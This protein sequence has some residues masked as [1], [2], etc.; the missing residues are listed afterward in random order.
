MGMYTTSLVTK[1]LCRRNIQQKS[2]VFEINA[3]IIFDMLMTY[4]G[5]YSATDFRKI[6]ILVN[7]IVKNTTS[8]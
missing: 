7:K 1:H 4:Y 6:Y 2:Y 3:L 5:S 8:G